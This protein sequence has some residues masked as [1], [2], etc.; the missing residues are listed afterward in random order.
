MTRSPLSFAAFALTGTALVVL[1]GCAATGTTAG[2]GAQQTPSKTPTVAAAV[3]VDNCGTPVTFEAA[4]ERV[5]TIKSTSTEMLLALGLGDRIVG[6][7]F[8]DGPVPA[9]LADSASALTTLSDQ[10]PSQE[11]VLNTEPD[12]VYAGWESN[13]SAEGAGERASLE[14]LG[15][16]T[17]VS[18]AACKEEGYK[19]TSLDFT[20][21]FGEISEVASIFHTDATPLLTAQQKTLDGITKSTAGLSALWYSSGDDTP[22]VGAGSGA[23]QLLLDTIGLTNIA[24]D[25]K[26]TWASYSWEAIVEANPDVIV[27]VD[28]AWNTAAQ[29]KE[30]LAANPATA[31]LDA[32]INQ[33]YLTIPFPASEAGV[34]SADA[35]ADLSTQLAALNL[36]D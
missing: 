13:F 20:Q 18:P 6:T 12:L 17:Y 3:T 35:A 22:Y 29:K 11:V 34:R 32:V 15:V 30:M 28:A 21:I 4:P 10:L 19:P 33:R 26:D 14:A 27:L 7:A 5:V 2:S 16:H 31:R 23:P 25:V 24:A 36:G 8:Q 1:S 9:S